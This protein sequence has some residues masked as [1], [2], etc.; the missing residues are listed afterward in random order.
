MDFEENKYYKISSKEDDFCMLFKYNSKNI[1]SHPFVSDYLLVVAEESIT[2]RNNAILIGKHNYIDLRAKIEE[3]DESIL[4]KAIKQFN[5]DK[6]AILATINQ[7]KSNETQGNT[8]Q[9]DYQL[10]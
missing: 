9:G 5:M 10:P 8:T 1:K 7:D 6:A 4:D 2:I 3:I